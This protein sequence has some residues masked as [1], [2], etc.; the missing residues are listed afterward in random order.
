MGTFEECV[1]E[2]IKASV[3]GVAERLR[4]KEAREEADERDDIAYALTVS[5]RV[6]LRKGVEARALWEGNPSLRP[7]A[8]GDDACEGEL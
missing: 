3:R 6:A 2:A 5:S 1:A 7:Q 8:R 4:A